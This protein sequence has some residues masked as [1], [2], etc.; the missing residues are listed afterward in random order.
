VGE[1]FFIIG[2]AFAFLDPVFSSGVLLAMTSGELTAAA[3]LAW[4]ANAR[5][6]M[7]LARRVERRLR[8]S[9]KRLGWL[10]YRINH[11]VFRE[12]FMAPSDLLHMRSGVVTLLAGNLEGGWRWS[13]P[14]LAFKIVFYAKSLAAWIGFN[15]TP[16]ASRAAG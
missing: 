11:P 8:H 5:A 3:A 12:M 4:L 16:P 13:G 6:G 2:D 15:P 1:G 14:L 7:R 9:M 10:V